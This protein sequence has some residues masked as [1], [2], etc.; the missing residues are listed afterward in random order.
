MD[1]YYL[2][3]DQTP[4]EKYGEDY[5]R[6]GIAPKNPVDNI[7]V[8][9]KEI[10]E[11]AFSRF[12][13]IFATVLVVCIVGMVCV[14]YWFCQIDPED[15]EASKLKIWQKEQHKRRVKILNKHSHLSTNFTVQSNKHSSS[16][17][18]DSVS[19]QSHHL[20]Q[21]IDEDDSLSQNR[22]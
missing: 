9:K 4:A 22:I 14:I 13:Y 3:Y 16:C 8:S 21:D 5:L 10:I 19:H 20:I 2:V 17:R 12:E 18:G 7:G 11:K 15:G 1:Q 6:V